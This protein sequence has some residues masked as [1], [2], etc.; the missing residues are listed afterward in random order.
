M[1]TSAEALS[2]AASVVKPPVLTT[3]V[4][5]VIS[6]GAYVFVLVV[7]LI[8][9]EIL[10]SKGKPRCFCWEGSGGNQLPSIDI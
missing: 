3:P 2:T 7:L 5:L 8:I 9:K 4:I 6:L 10:V 1:A